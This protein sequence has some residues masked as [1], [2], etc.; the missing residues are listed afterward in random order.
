MKI[1]I[2]SKNPTKI[3]AVTEVFE[4]MSS[5][6]K[7]LSV[8]AASQI[9]DQPIGLEITVQGAKNRARN[10]YDD[11]D[12][13]VG[14]ESGI[15]T[16]DQST[17]M[18]VAACAIYD[19][20]EY[21]LGLSPAFSLPKDVS[22]LIKRE[23]V[24]VDTAVHKLGLSEDPRTGYKEGI[25]GILTNGKLTRKQYTKPAIEMALVELNFKTNERLEILNTTAR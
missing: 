1:S 4:S 8:D 23:K 16:P 17:Y 7:F 2:G 10:A 15:I 13:S 24:D 3:G 12:L 19:G 25:I 22:E 11:C 14:I 20:E 5:E 6:Y 9:P 21:F 18:I